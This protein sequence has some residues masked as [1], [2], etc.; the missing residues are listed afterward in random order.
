MYLLWN[1]AVGFVYCLSAVLYLSM[2]M[3][4]GPHVWTR[5]PKV[6]P[7]GAEGGAGAALTTMVTLGCFQLN[8]LHTVKDW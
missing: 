7:V 1:L 6:F 3:T 8:I 2:Y 5:R 4:V